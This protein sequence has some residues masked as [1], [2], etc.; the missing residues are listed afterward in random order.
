MNINRESKLRKNFHQA[1]W[2][3]EII[4]QLH[5][6]GQRGVIPPQTEKEIENKVLFNIE[7]LV[8]PYLERLKMIEMDKRQAAY[9][10]VL[11]SN[12][13]NIISPLARN[14]SMR[15]A[16]FSPVEIQVANLIRQGRTTKEIA[17]LLNIAKSTVDSHRYQIRRKL[18]IKGEKINLRS[19]LERQL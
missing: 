15:Y 14:L 11:E 2:D 9:I 17:A 19:F 10:N 5:S 3:E 7:K 12:L 8:M 1:K 13:K 4:F 16:A 6:K 18:R